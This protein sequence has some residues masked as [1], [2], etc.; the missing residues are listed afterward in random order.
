MSDHYRL[1]WEGVL[2]ALFALFLILFAGRTGVR[3]I[4]SFVLTVLTLWKV[5]VPLYLNGVD[6]IWVGLAVTLVLTVLIIAVV[7]LFVVL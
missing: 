2:A 5:L 7:L 6:P 1:G 3:A 4:A